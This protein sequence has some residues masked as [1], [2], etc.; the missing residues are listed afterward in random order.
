MKLTTTNFLFI[1]FVSMFS[2][3]YG[4]EDSNKDTKSL[5]SVYYNDNFNPFQKSNWFVAFSSTLNNEK[6]ENS[7]FRFEKIYEGN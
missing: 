5:M 3:I 1:V 6:F 4:Q 2:V 7:E